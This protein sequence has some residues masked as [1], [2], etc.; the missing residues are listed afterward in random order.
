MGR[1]VVLSGAG[2]LVNV[3]GG[4]FVPCGGAGTLLGDVITKEGPMGEDRNLQV[5][6]EGSLTQMVVNVVTRSSWKVN[7]EVTAVLLLIDTRSA[8]MSLLVINLVIVRIKKKL[9]KKI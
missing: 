9:R 7:L 4:S 2:M 8:V 6:P 3:R 1:G 5:A